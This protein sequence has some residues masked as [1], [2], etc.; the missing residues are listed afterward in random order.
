[1]YPIFVNRYFLAKVRKILIVCIG[2][3][4]FSL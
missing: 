4:R 3:W 2:C 1:M